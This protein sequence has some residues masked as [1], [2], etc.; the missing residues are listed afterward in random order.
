MSRADINDVLNY[1]NEWRSSRE[2]KKEFGFTNTEWHN[3]CKWLLKG[4][5]V[6]RVSTVKKN[7]TNRVYLYKII[8]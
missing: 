2:V 7:R 4:G 8:E 6:K 1:L 5:F 3:T